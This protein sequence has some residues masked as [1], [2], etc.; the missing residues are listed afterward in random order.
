MTDNSLDLN[1]TVGTGGSLYGPLDRAVAKVTSSIGRLDAAGISNH[2]QIAN[3][4]A[5]GQIETTRLELNAAETTINESGAGI[6]VEV[7]VP[8]QGGWHSLG[9]G[10]ERELGQHRP[11]HQYSRD[12]VLL[13]CTFPTD[14]AAAEIR[15]WRRNTALALEEHVDHN[16]HVIQWHNDGLDSVVEKAIQVRKMQLDAVRSLSDEIGTTGI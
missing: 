15:K 12:V 3:A 1:R 10:Q 9:Y 14:T 8:Y 6:G 7:R 11:L 13:T 4:K 2:D 16:N 5:V